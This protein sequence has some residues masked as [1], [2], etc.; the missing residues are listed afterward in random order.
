[1]GGESRAEPSCAQQISAIQKTVDA[2]GAT[3]M[4]TIH[5]QVY[6]CSEELTAEL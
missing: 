5:L 2:G 4:H 3:Y 6:L 1:M